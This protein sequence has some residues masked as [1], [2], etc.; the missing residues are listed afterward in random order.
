M[1]VL[2]LPATQANAMVLWGEEGTR[3]MVAVFDPAS[4]KVRA[5]LRIRSLRG[6]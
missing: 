4:L 5:T 2:G 6:P 3:P 1:A